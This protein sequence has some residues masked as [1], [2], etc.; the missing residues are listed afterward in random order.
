M[1]GEYKNKGKADGEISEKIESE[2]SNKNTLNYEENIGRNNDGAV[3]LKKDSKKYVVLGWISAALTIF[4][5]PIFAILGVIFGILLNEQIRGS[6][7]II[8]ITNVVLALFVIALQILYLL[9]FI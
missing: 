8:I 6:G 2:D 7:N 5:S 4:I 9:M 3:I 1:D